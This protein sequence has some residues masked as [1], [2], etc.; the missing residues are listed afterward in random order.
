VRGSMFA[1]KGMPT[2]STEV[3][4]QPTVLGPASPRLRRYAAVLT[5]GNSVEA[6]DLAQD[7][8]VRALS[9]THL[10]Q[11]GT[12][13]RAWL[14]T[15]LHNT[16][17]NRVRMAARHGTAVGLGEGERRLVSAP[18][19]DQRLKVRDLQRAL[20]R[21]PPEQQQ[22][23]YLIGI[24]GMRYEEVAAIQ[25]VPEGTVRSRLSRGRDALW[26]LLSDRSSDR[27]PA[28]LRL[29]APVPAAAIASARPG[30]RKR[31]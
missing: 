6:D 11:D 12:D 17:V 29:C 20:T 16:F 25:R 30:R 26:V 28:A 10:W 21:L 7:C 18:N 9:R 24:E 13:L 19:Q 15:I 2:K 1:R 22:V 3:G 31:G 14:F 23:L 5:R 4:S 8:L 27:Q